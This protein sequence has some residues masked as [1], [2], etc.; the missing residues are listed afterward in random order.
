MNA[1]NRSR[2]VAGQ[3][4]AACAALKRHFGATLLAIHLLGPALDG[5]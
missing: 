1:A 3:M 4:A 2:R 5:G